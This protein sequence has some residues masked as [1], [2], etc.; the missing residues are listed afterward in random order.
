MHIT[1]YS[2]IL[3]NKVTGY[4]ASRYLTYAIQCINSLFIA[5]YLEPY[6]L[7]IWGFVTLILQ[8]MNQLNL[9]IS[10]S[11]NAIISIHKEKEWYVQKTTFGI[12]KLLWGDKIL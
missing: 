11:V 4:I 10:H 7:G 6:Y 12:K 5:V 1:K 9:G 2:K 3:K 8:Y